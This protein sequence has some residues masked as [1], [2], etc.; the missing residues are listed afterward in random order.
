MSPEQAVHA[1]G[2]TLKILEQPDLTKALE[3]VRLDLGKQQE[4]SFA[5][6]TDPDGEAWTPPKRDY[7]NPLLVRTGLMYLSVGDQ[8]DGATIDKTVLAL[9]EDDSLPEY[10][11]YQDRG[12]DLIP[13]R[14][15][16]GFGQATLDRAQEHGTAELNEQLLGVWK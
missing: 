6:K 8:V 11:K 13:A 3:Q 16:L 7:G 2:E 1:L 12:T 4:H 5:S 15:F 14:P 10:T 9:P